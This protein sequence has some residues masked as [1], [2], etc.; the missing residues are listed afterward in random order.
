[1]NGASWADQW[2]NSGNS[3]KGGRIGGG[4]VISSGGGG[5][6]SNSN[7]AKYK[8]KLGLGLD[9]TKAVASSGFKKLKNGSATGFRWVKDK[10]HKTTNKH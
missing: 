4:A 1:M 7:T 9:K 6:A 8:E 2:D 3:A 10:Y 5:A